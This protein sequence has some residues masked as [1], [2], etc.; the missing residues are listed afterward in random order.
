[1]KTTINIKSFE[2]AFRE[3]LA[4]TIN[5]P[6]PGYVVIMLNKV[7]GD[8]YVT[9]FSHKCTTCILFKNEKALFIVSRWPAEPLHRVLND[10]FLSLIEGMRAEL[11]QFYILA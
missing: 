7:T 8:C 5:Y 11:A 6:L 9:D 4:E 1:M 3:A 2:N 10:R